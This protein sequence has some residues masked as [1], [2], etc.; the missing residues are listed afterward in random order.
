MLLI[1]LAVDRGVAA[2][3]QNQALAAI[4]FLY[5]EVLGADPGW[6]G[7]IVRAKRPQRL[8]VVLTLQ[9][10]QALLAA[11]DGVPWIMSMLLYGSGL[12]LMECL[13]L[14]VKDKQAT[15]AWGAD[16]IRT[17]KCS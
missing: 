1:S 5:R 9:E 10:V 8:P 17:S 2:S 7:D 11:L 15:A 3:T 6:L 4:L 16:F 12:R 13:R 14:R